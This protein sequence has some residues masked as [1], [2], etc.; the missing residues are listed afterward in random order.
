MFTRTA[1]ISAIVPK[2]QYLHTQPARM[3]RRKPQFFP[4]SPVLPRG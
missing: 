4:L 2:T 1:V 3:E